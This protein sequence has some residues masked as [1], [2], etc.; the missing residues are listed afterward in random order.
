MKSRAHQS[1]EELERRIVEQERR[2]SYAQQ[3]YRRELE[4]ASL[5]LEH[6]EGIIRSLIDKVADVEEVR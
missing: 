5:A 1:L 2:A 4:R 6:K 3:E